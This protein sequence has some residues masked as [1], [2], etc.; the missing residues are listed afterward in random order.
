M[1]FYNNFMQHFQ[2][3][4]QASASLGIFGAAIMAIWG[5]RTWQ[6]T[7]TRKQEV[8]VARARN[9]AACDSFILRHGL[10]DCQSIVLAIDG[11]AS[12]EARKQYWD[13]DSEQA[14]PDL[15]RRRSLETY[16]VVGLAPAAHHEERR[17]LI[18][19][20]TTLIARIVQCASAG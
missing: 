10:P 18:H 11:V 5:L 7:L 13:P 14:L 15:L 17:S 2:T 6:S 3:R 9:K 8:K 16:I 12:L 4:R 20:P 19:S 1:I